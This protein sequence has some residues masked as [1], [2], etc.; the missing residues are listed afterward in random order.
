[1][2][3]IKS[4]PHI[5]RSAR[6]VF[7]RRAFRPGDVIEITPVILIPNTQRALIR[8]T[9]LENYVFDWGCG[10]TAVAL[11]YGSLYNHA[12]APNAH[13]CQDI[14]RKTLEFSAIRDI[15]AGDE[16]TVNYNGSSESSLPMWFEVK[17]RD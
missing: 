4:S 9:V 7:A 12:Y 1:M 6:G 16:I 15:A 13:Y 11:G 14:D 2:T 5:G 8:Q 10:S 3:E 17:D